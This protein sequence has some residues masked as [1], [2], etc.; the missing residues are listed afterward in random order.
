MRAVFAGELAH[1]LDLRVQIG[2]PGHRPPEAGAEAVGQ[3]ARGVGVAGA[4]LEDDGEDG[5]AHRAA[6]LLG[7]AGGEEI[8]DT[9]FLPLVR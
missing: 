5:D 2:P 9:V 8:V 7:D 3:G 6:D 4:V 1:D